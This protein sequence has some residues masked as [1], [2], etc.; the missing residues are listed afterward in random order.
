MCNND[1]GDPPRHRHLGSIAHEVLAS[2]ELPSESTHLVTAT[3]TSKPEQLCQ[4]L[5]ATTRTRQK[6]RIFAA[7]EHVATAVHRIAKHPVK[8]T[9]TR[10]VK[11][12]RSGAPLQTPDGKHVVH[13]ANT[14]PIDIEFV[15]REGVKLTVGNATMQLP[16]G[17]I[18][19]DA[20]TD[21]PE[22]LFLAD[23]SGT[24]GEWTI[25]DG[26]GTVVTTVATQ[27]DL[28]AADPYVQDWFQPD[29]VSYCGDIAVHYPDPTTEDELET[30]EDSPG[31]T[32]SGNRPTLNEF[33]HR[34][35]VDYHGTGLNTSE[36]FDRY[37]AWMHTSGQSKPG[38]PSFAQALSQLEDIETVTRGKPPGQEV[39]CDR[40][41]VPTSVRLLSV[42]H[43]LR[44]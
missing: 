29:R 25:T 23:Q 42:P 17:E 7:N 36:V 9:T 2:D 24:D 26:D 33:L 21:L 8:E 18:P 5:Q 11:P 27:E 35:S 19:V 31:Q 30:Y 34:F 13:D 32:L 16:F 20:F 14:S 28:K 1:N 44:Y 3:G 39:L 40:A 41:G 12:Y 38:R 22:G 6:T 4:Q 43:Y 15:A 37:A 10:G